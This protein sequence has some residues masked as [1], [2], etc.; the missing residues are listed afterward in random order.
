MRILVSAWLT[1]V[2][3]AFRSDCPGLGP[4]PFLEVE[5]D[6]EMVRESSDDVPFSSLAFKIMTDP[7]VGV[8]T[9]ARI[10]SGVLNKGDQVRG[11]PQP[12]VGDNSGA[13][14]RGVRSGAQSGKRGARGPLK[15]FLPC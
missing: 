3:L 12:L 14:G 11:R 13:L 10:Y 6:E 8:L 9:F 1:S 4:C 15:A 2:F 5:G 7:F